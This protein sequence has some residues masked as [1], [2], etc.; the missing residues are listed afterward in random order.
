MFDDILKDFREK[1]E[2]INEKLDILNK[3]GNSQIEILSTTDIM[4]ILSINRNQ[5]ND[6]FKRPD[7]PKIKGI[8]SNKVERTA[9]KKWLQNTEY[10]ERS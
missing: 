2:A 6:L 9:F 7:F 10:K 1:L 3:E 4:A 5:A 8:K